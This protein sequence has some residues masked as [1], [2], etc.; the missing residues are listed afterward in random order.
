MNSIIYPDKLDTKFYEKTILANPNVILDGFYYG[1]FDKTY[2][3]SRVELVNSYKFIYTCDYWLDGYYWHDDRSYFHVADTN[4]LRLVEKKYGEFSI[5][6][7]CL[8]IAVKHRD[9]MHVMSPDGMGFDLLF[10][11]KAFHQYLE[12][13]K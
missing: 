3:E 5:P 10:N 8:I 11:K 4:V 13:N 12:L 6:L 9:E 1:P 2:E 7:G